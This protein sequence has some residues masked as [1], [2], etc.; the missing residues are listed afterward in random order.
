[1]KAIVNTAPDQLTLLDLPLPEPQPRQVRIRT[2][3]CGICATDL[4]M[5]AGWERTRFP[6]IPGH[7]WS[8]VVDAVG[9]AVDP[10][11]I[12]QRCVAENVLADGGEVGFEHPGGYGA[13]FL[14]EARN[15]RLL[16]PEFPPSVAVLVEPLAVCVRALRRLNLRE[17]HTALISGDGSIG[18]LTLMLLRH[19][20]VEQIAMIG[21]R[22][23]RL[24]LARE[25]GASATFHFAHYGDN[26]IRVVEHHFGGKLPCIVEASG[27]ADGLQNALGLIAREGQLLLIGD[28]R[29]TRADFPWNLIVHRELQLIGSNA[30]AGAWDEAVRLA[31]EERLPLKRLFSLTFPAARYEEA[32]ALVRSQR[33]DVV[34]IV[35][36]W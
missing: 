32:F 4:E 35:L 23:G 22:T 17:Q 36:E 28:Y 5:I 13:Y 3:A 7:E 16:P 21:G 25:L 30:S 11:L 24:A 8:G 26:L 33:D 27:S 14:T 2:I 34:K 29:A 10:A 18:L 1:V 20:G 6:A 12:G 15:L 31:V 9:I 19:A